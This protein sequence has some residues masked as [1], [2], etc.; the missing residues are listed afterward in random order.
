[1]PENGTLTHAQ[2]KTPK[3]AAMAGIAF[4]LLIFAILGLLRHLFRSIRWRPARGLL[5]IQER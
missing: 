3:A 5:P 1:M 4:S 2:L